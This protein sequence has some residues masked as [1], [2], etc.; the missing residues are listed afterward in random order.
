MS[1][2]AVTDAW[3]CMYRDTI[4]CLTGTDDG[5]LLAHNESKLWYDVID[6]IGRNKREVRVYRRVRDNN[7]G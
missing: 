2:R 6:H 3:N 1:P 4:E 5:Y 7:V